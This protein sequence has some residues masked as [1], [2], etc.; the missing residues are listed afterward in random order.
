MMT[1]KKVQFDFDKKFLKQFDKLSVKVQRKF[2]ERFA[3]YRR[4]AQGSVLRVH[5]LRGRWEGCLSMNV[6]GDVRAV[7]EEKDSGR[8]I[9]FREIGTHSELYGK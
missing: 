1:M 4:D 9:V 7:F 8:V 2:N 3:L 6:T 5:K